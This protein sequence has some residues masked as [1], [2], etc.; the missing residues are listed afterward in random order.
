MR[1]LLAFISLLALAGIGTAQENSDFYTY[2]DVVNRIETA[3]AS[4]QR[5]VDLSNMALTVFPPEL[6]NFYDLEHLNLS[7]NELTTLPL[8]SAISEI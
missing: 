7:A 3:R 1:L 6:L 4:G 8:K 2:E 5:G